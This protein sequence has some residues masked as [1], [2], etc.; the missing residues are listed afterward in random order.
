MAEDERGCVI[1]RE[2][3]CVYSICG[4]IV[5]TRGG[6]ERLVQQQE[7]HEQRG[8]VRRGE[9]NKKSTPLSAEHPF[10]EQL[11]SAASLDAYRLS[12]NREEEEENP[13]QCTGDLLDLDY[14]TQA[15]KY[16]NLA[17]VE[18]SFTGPGVF[19]RRFVASFV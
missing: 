9:A 2:L 15:A 5:S 8:G 13:P 17:T 12:S 4:H 19:L 7:P 16:L 14:N 10:T 11:M 1:V 6:R 18:K 3:R